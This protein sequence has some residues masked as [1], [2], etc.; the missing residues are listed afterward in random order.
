MLSK[1]L[2]VVMYVSFVI[3]TVC[4]ISLIMSG[5]A[6]LGGIMIL[7]VLLMVHIDIHN[8]KKGKQYG[9]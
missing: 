3:A 6:V 9:G 8:R 1:V 2:N 7:L 4:A 5:Q